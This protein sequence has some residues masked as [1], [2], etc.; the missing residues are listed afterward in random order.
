[1]FGSGT[2]GVRFKSRAD[3]IFHTLPMI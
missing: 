2:G 3:Q 1:M